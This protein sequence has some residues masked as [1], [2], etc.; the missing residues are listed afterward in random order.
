MRSFLL[1]VAL[2]LFS[3]R[4]W[5]QDLPQLAPAQTTGSVQTQN[6][7]TRCAPVRFSGE[8]IRDER[9]VRALPRNLEFR[10]LPSPE[11]W[12]ISIG[13]PGD[14]TEDYAGIATPPYHGVNPVFIEAWHFRNADNTGPNDGQVNA[15]TNVRD[16]SFVLTRAAYAKFLNALNIWS[17]SATATEMQRDAA[18]SFLLNAP[19]QA[20]TL[21]ITNMKLGGLEKGTHP[22]FDSMNFKVELCFPPAPAPAPKKNP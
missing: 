18:T 20:G 5:C 1:L 10:L 15:P 16:F 19:R 6:S 4:A 11:G 3:A 12:S 2:F 21:T 22:W 13:R 9:Y 14:K 17:G 7:M 8:V